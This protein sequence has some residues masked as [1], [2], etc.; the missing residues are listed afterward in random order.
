[1]SFRPVASIHGATIQNGIRVT[2]RTPPASRSAGKAPS[3]RLLRPACSW[4]VRMLASSPDR[5]STSMA[6]H[7]ITDLCYA[8]TA[9]LSRHCVAA[10]PMSLCYR[11][12]RAMHDRK[13]FQPRGTSADMR[14][15]PG[16]RRVHAVAKLLIQPQLG[17]V[18]FSVERLFYKFYGINCR[19]KLG[20]KLLDRF[21]HRWR[22]I[23]PPV[24]DAT[25]RFFDGPQHVLYRFFT[26]SSRHSAVA[27][28]FVSISF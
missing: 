17:F 6:A 10:R 14:S 9:A 3:R 25:H 2:C 24:N 20:A 19:S 21:F 18:Y 16:G 1:M 22:Q 5:R 13:A 4:S 7:T 15:V 27:S 12:V 26:V 11:Y 28:L 8:V 23:S